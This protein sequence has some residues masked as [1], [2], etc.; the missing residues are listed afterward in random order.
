MS[1]P[2]VSAVYPV[3]DAGNVV[4]RTKIWVEFDQP[5]D[6][7]TI[8]AS[9]FAV[10]APDSTLVLNPSEALDPRRKPSGSR[11]VAGR[12]VQESPVRFSFV[13]SEPLQPQAKYRVLIVGGSGTA[14]A[15]GVKNLAGEVLA[16][17]YQW[18]FTTGTLD[19]EQPPLTSPVNLFENQAVPGPALADWLRPRLDP[20]QIEV[21]PV[22]RPDGQPVDGLP[23]QFE[24]VFPG[25]V[26]PSV[27]SSGQVQVWL[28]SLADIP[29]MALPA[30]VTAVASVSGNKILVTLQGV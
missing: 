10:L 11:P 19:L 25:Q 12:I 20:S 27:L 7:A 5:M 14:V 6:P 22:M 17:S 4:L 21:R 8:T 1:A 26:N 23:F 15:S 29:Q 30:G 16:K 3:P 18:S 24:I 28:E 2:V 9:T 13:P